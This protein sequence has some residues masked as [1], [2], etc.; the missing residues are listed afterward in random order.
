MIGEPCLFASRGQGRKPVCGLVIG[1]SNGIVAV[2]AWEQPAALLSTQAGRALDSSKDA[3]F[4]KVT[5]KAV[6]V[7]LQ[8]GTGG[9]VKL[10]ATGTSSLHVVRTGVVVVVLWYVG[11]F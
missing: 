4:P 3:S 11:T 5:V 2:S 7:D 1:D 6:L 10:V 9:A 8:Q